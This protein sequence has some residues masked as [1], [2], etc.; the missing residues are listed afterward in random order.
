MTLPADFQFSQNNLQDYL[1]CPRR[2]ELR[3]LR[4][5]AWPAVQTE[6]VIEQEQAMQRGSHFHHMLHQA[7]IGIPPQVTNDPHL[8]AWWQNYLDF[9][10]QGLPERRHPEFT[11]HAPFAGY[12]LIAK[13]DLIAIAPGQQAIIVDWKTN[14]R[15][16]P[17]AFLARR[18]QTRLYRFLLVTAGHSLNANARIQ[19]EQVQMIYWFANEPRQPETFSYSHAEHEQTGQE[20]HALIEEI[21]NLSQAALPFPL[22]ANEKHC[23]F[24]PYRSLCGRGVRAGDWQDLEDDLDPEPTLQLDFEQI[25]E[26][27]F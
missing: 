23:A 17:R 5:L 8:A 27:S 21:C 14:P 19:P 22:T 6:P 11:L 4:R 16:T 26:I 3:A 15:R 10:P 9:P 2:F 7:A 25:G 18:M 24:C 12:R 13:F 1:D 20:L